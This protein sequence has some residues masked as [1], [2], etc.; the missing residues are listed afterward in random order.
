MHQLG[1]GRTSWMQDSNSALN[2][3]LGQSFKSFATYG[4]IHT[5]DIRKSFWREHTWQQHNASR[6]HWA[7]ISGNAVESTRIRI[8]GDKIK[9]KTEIQKC[10]VHLMVE[11]EHHSQLGSIDCSSKSTPSHRH[12]LGR[13]TESRSWARGFEADWHGCRHCCAAAGSGGQALRW[14]FR[15][16]L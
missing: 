1:F 2:H 3:L 16:R 15:S 9:D 8:Q 10:K 12:R 14:W 6:W 7:W 11:L 5:A 13:D 4:H